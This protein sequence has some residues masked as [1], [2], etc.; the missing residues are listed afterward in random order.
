MKAHLKSGSDVKTSVVR[1]EPEERWHEVFTA[2]SKNY[3]IERLSV[4][5]L[6]KELLRT[7]AQSLCSNEEESRVSLDVCTQRV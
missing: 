1:G 5:W 2:R 3:P 7:V 6:V 4:E